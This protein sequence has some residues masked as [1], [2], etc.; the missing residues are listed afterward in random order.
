VVVFSY[1]GY[2]ERGA[3]SWVKNLVCES[4]GDDIHGYQSPPL[5]I[6]LERFD[7]IPTLGFFSLV[8]PYN[9]ALLSH[10]KTVHMSVQTPISPLTTSVCVV[11]EHVRSV[12]SLSL[13]ET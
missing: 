12:L 6:H 10:A 7:L 5:R 4:D 2:G 13:V 9:P 8:K 1:R 11:A 3:G